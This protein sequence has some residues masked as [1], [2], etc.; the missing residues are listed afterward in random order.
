MEALFQGAAK[1]V[2]ERGEKLGINQAVRDAVL[3][4][5]RNVQEA[6]SSMKA[7]RDLLNEPGSSTTVRAVAMLDRRNRRLASLLGEPLSALKNLAGSDDLEDKRKCQDA[8]EIA[9]AKLQFVKIYLEDSTMT[10]PDEEEP[11][12]SLTPS[13]TP[14]TSGKKID[15][16]P[17]SDA[18]AA[19]ALNLSTPT[20]APPNPQDAKS[21]VDLPKPD[22]DRMDTDDPLGS[23]TP[24]PVVVVERKLERPQAPIPTRS[25]LAQSSFS[26]M[27]EPDDTHSSS[28]SSSQPPPIFPSKLPSSDGGGSSSNSHR[29]RPSANANRERTAFLFGEVSADERGQTV[30]PEDIFGL[31]EIRKPKS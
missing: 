9:V 29:K 13:A 21:P 26:W 11:A 22:P 14:T 5:R 30:L 20:T 31:E 27:L 24:A 4:I 25:T 2:L 23:G 6:K 12:S 1:G 8:L 3:E 28:P 17:L 18:V 15:P 7:G 19:L 16:G 10:L